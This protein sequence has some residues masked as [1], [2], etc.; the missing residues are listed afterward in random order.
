M[1]NTDSKIR[2]DRAPYPDSKQLP[3][4]YAAFIKSA[5][6]DMDRNPEDVA[7]YM[8]LQIAS[9]IYA[10]ME[11]QGID[12][13]ELA[14]RLGKSRQYVSRV[15]NERTN[16]TLDSL[17]RIACA[18][19]MRVAVRFFEHDQHLDILPDAKPKKSLVDFDTHKDKKK[20]KPSP[21]VRSSRKAGGGKG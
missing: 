4:D 3:Q 19:N 5:L 10:A 16:F 14:R 17:A 21:R 13:S 18:L 15:L 20:A 8:K 6:H 1:K 2:E 12:Q 11:K 7:A 9:D